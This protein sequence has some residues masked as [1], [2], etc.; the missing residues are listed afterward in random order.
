M[1]VLFFSMEN[2]IQMD[3]LGVHSFQET[4]ETSMFDGNM[5]G[6]YGGYTAVVT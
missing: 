2:P 3:D 1:D 4:Q 5:M 6:M